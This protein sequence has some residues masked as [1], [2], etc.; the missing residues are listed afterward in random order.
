MKPPA[1]PHALLFVGQR[2]IVSGPL[3]SITHKSD[4]SL[5]TSRLP[6]SL[7]GKVGWKEIFR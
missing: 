6:V 5:T 2:R 3:Q 4:T 7:G 1:S